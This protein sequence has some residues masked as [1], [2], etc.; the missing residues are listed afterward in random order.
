V[1]LEVLDDAWHKALAA[2]LDPALGRVGDN[3]AATAFSAC[4][5][6]RE[7]VVFQERQ[8]SREAGGERLGGCAKRCPRRA[9]VGP[10]EFLWGKIHFTSHVYSKC[11]RALVKGGLG[12]PP[13]PKTLWREVRRVVVSRVSSQSRMISVRALS[14]SGA[15][16]QKRGGPALG[17]ETGDVGG[18]S[19]LPPAPSRLM[20]SAK[21]R[22][23]SSSISSSHS[24]SAI[25]FLDLALPLLP[26]RPFPAPE[27]RP[28]VPP[29][30]GVASAP[31]FSGGQQWNRIAGR[32]LGGNT[33]RQRAPPAP[34][35]G[36]PQLH[37]ERS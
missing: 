35:H 36:A 12:A 4:G 3:D 25:G 37:T 17:S 31:F 9:L 30:L 11:K 21:A 20:A 18:D 29:F 1:I 2:L 26:R 14:A 22:A 10:D 19:P 33:A 8:I 6:E 23:I 15:S 5:K 34:E 32:Y 16:W 27:L 28:T 13:G 7:H 24:T